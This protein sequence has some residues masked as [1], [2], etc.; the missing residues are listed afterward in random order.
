MSRKFY[1]QNAALIL[2]RFRGQ[3]FHTKISNSMV[4]YLQKNDYGSYGCE[5]AFLT[6]M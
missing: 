5:E 2:S 3:G 1:F 6:T 4:K